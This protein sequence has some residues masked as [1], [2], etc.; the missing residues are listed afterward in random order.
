[1]FL[2]KPGHG[3][4]LETAVNKHNETYHAGDNG[5]GILRYVS[6]GNYGGWYV[7][8]LSGSYSGLD[9]RPTDEKHQKDWSE[10]VD[11]HVAEYGFTTLWRFNENL[12]TGMEI[13]QA[14]SKYRVWHVQLKDGQAYRFGPLMEKMRKVQADEGNAFIIYNN[15]IN[16]KDQTDLVILFPF[17]NYAEWDEEGSD[18]VAAYEDEYGSGSW[19]SFLDEWRD[20][21]DSMDEEV[22]ESL[23]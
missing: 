6:Y 18:I 5:Q 12:S 3:S 10:N 21:V 16:M 13:M 7:W 14:S 22:H 19:V 11:Q 15:V 4:A 23:N 2:T 17:N 9:S 1:M 20:I 8:F